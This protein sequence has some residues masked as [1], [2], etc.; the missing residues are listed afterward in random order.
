MLL[1]R[2]KLQNFLVFEEVDLE[3]KQVKLA[4][5]IGQF[6]SDARRSNG[7][8]K[9]AFMEAVR[10]ALFDQ[11]RSKNKAG[12]VRTGAEKCH[13]EIQFYAAPCHIRVVR[14]RSS[15]GTSSAK[16]WVDGKLS[17]DKV[18]VV[19]EVVAE[20]LGMDAELFD[21]IYFFKQGD[22]F[23]FA[24]AS[25]GDRKAVLAKVFRMDALQRC[26]AN[27]KARLGAAREQLQRAKGVQ[28][29]ASVALSSMWTIDHYRLAELDASHQLACQEQMVAELGPLQEELTESVIEFEGERGKW[30]DEVD[31]K[32]AEVNRLDGIISQCSDSIAQQQAQ[33]QEQDSEVTQLQS[34]LAQLDSE[35][36][37]PTSDE[38]KMVADSNRLARE[39]IHA[40]SNA[41]SN[42]QR[43]RDVHKIDI[44]T[45]GAQCPTCLQVIGV[46]H[47]ESINKKA[48]DEAARC[49]GAAQSYS[50]DAERLQS[51]LGRCNFEIQKW[52]DYNKSLRHRESLERAIAQAK[53]RVKQIDESIDDL[54]RR[55]ND[56]NAQHV[57]ALQM[58]DIHLVDVTRKGLDWHYHNR[59]EIARGLR[60]EWTNYW[61]SSQQSAFQQSS[62]ER[63]IKERERADK[64]LER[65]TKEVE[66]ADRNVRVLTALDEAF[67]KNGIQ[68]LI[69][70]NAL[71][72]IEDFANDILKQMQTRFLVELRTQKQTKVGEDRESLDVIVFD[73]GNERAFENYSGGE[74]TLVNLA[75]RLSLSRVISSLH[76]V[77]M[78][79]LFLDEVLGALDE[80]NREEVVK[81][82]AFLSRSFDQVFVISH[83]DEI[84]DI[85]DSSITI[86][87]HDHHSEVVLANSH[88]ND[89]CAA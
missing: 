77:K 64:E 36:V 3:L 28:D 14:D 16:V 65:A 31:A 29:A 18:R 8:G 51:E 13:V 44:S 67:G 43:A 59:S 89:P 6:E 61:N 23:G 24:E 26:Q 60:A 39:V 79:S 27:V 62:A 57:E 30:H 75:L 53:K 15:N 22:Q 55:R 32:R 82:V 76:G 81:V 68:A 72:V 87:R 80:V 20:R 9:T 33:R 83:T 17:G 85:I 66:R 38:E 11:T 78:Q 42:R 46:D 73:N 1:E 69:I 47:A 35:V 48:A 12:I 2:L 52:N 34:Q 86:L 21:L 5:I 10:Y 56:A 88:T 19:N 50:A 7:A 41:S 84:K 25:P 70:E 40:Q 71:G 37:K 45:A 4:S 63:D 54:E 58:I 74:R 49:L